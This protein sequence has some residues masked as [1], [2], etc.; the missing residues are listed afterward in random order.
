M[1]DPT[2]SNFTTYFD[3][4]A[5]QVLDGKSADEL[6]ELKEDDATAFEGAFELSSS[7]SL[8]QRPG[9]KRSARQP[10]QRKPRSRLRRSARGPASSRPRRGGRGKRGSK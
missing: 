9:W 10:P 6:Q 7:S 3:D 2:G 1:A 8:R 5:K 4:I